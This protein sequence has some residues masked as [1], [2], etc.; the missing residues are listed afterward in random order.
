M[1]DLRTAAGPPQEPGQSLNSSTD[2]PTKSEALVEL[3]EEVTRLGTQ[4]TVLKQ[5][6]ADLEALVEDMK[7][8]PSAAALTGQPLDPNQ[9][10]GISAFDAL[11][12]DVRSTAWRILSSVVEEELKCVVMCHACLLR[13]CSL[14]CSLSLALVALVARAWGDAAGTLSQARSQRAWSA[15]R[16][17]RFRSNSVA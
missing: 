13:F 8:H 6:T 12:D 5:K 14:I 3:E 1:V 15:R 2:D 16:Q 17:K 9:L 11:P 7:R 10:N 4:N